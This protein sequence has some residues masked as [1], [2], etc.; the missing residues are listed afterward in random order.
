MQKFKQVAGIK[1]HMM[2]KALQQKV[3]QRKKQQNAK[4]NSTKK[5]A[6]IGWDQIPAEI[7]ET[8]REVIIRMH[9]PGIDEDEIGISI[10]NGMIKV[11]TESKTDNVE[12][13]DFIIETEHRSLYRLISLP[14][15]VKAEGMKKNFHNEIL[16][17]ALPKNKA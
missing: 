1:S 14:Q 7:N 12:Q 2:K 9:M 8:S 17:I 16:E 4:K 5:E 6:S 3:L 10:N 15:G 11:K 13:G